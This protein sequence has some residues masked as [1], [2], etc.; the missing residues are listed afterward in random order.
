MIEAETRKTEIIGARV[1]SITFDP[2]VMISIRH[3]DNT[4]ASYPVKSGATIRRNGAKTSF[5]ELVEGDKVDVTLDYGQISAVVAIG[6]EKEVVGT[7]E[8]IVI[9]K[10][11]SMLK[12]NVSGATATY[13]IS[14]DASI[15]LDDAAANI[16]DLRLGYQ[17]ILKTSSSTVTE[18]TVKSV[19]TP[20]QITGEITLINTSYGM[21]RV[22]FIDANGEAVEEQ[23]FIKDEAKILD[24][25]DGKMKDLKDLKV[26]QNV[27]VAG[28]E[29]VGIFEANSIMI[30]N[31]TK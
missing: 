24:S 30:L 28:A 19:A 29:N 10:S 1:E 5:S 2:D 8:E 13:S 25:N 23:I 20:L 9:S 14:R 3:A 26:G 4:L 7:I 15:K 12:V 16:Y 17:V 18:I 22:A 6:V 31:H 27:T 21:I 11:N